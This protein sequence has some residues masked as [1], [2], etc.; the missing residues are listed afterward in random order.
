MLEKIYQPFEAPTNRCSLDEA[1]FQK[2]VHNT[3]NAVKIAFFNEMRVVANKE[4]WDAGRVFTATAE[5]SE[6][7]WNPMYGLRDHGPFDG[8][9][10]PKDTRALLQWGDNNDHDLVILRSIIAANIE[11]EAILGKNETVRVNYLANISL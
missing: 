2:Y 4:G 8:S 1:E 3:Y 9:C 7:I 6:G 11:H 5:S 10:L